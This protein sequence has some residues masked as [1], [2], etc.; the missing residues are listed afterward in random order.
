MSEIKK[1]YRNNNIVLEHRRKEKA[2][3]IVYQN[4]GWLLLCFGASQVVG[5]HMRYKLIKE[6]EFDD[7]KLMDEF[8]C[9]ELEITKAQLS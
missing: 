5:T 6:V 2:Y 7:P 4:P 3:E 1:F 8:I 9:D